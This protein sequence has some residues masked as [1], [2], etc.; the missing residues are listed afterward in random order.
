MRVTLVLSDLAPGAHTLAL[1]VWAPGAYV[2]QDFSRHVFD[3]RAVDAA[4]SALPVRKTA[5]NVWELT[6]SDVVT[7]TYQVYAFQLADSGMHADRT[8]AYWNGTNLFFIVDG[9]TDQPID[10]TIRAPEG[11]YASTGLDPVG[12]APLH[13]HAP[14]YD[15][16]V[17]CPV[18]VG[19]HRRYTFQVDGKRHELAIWGSGNERPERLVEDLAKIV[20]AAADIFGELPYPHYTF[21]LHIVDLLPGTDSMWLPGWGGLEHRNSTTCG[22]V[23][24]AFAPWSQYREVLYLFSHE[25]FHLW[26][27]KRIHPDMLGPFDYQ[28][29]VYT[30]LLWA[31]EGFTDY[32]AYLILRRAGLYTVDEY[33]AA[34]A[35]QIRQL[36]TRPGRHWT[37]LAAA[38]FDSWIA[39]TDP[40]PDYDNRSVNYYLKGGLVGLL[41]DLAIRRRTQNRKSLDDVLRR[42]MDRYGR[43]GRGFPERVYQETVEEV[44]GGSMGEFFARYIEGVD[45]LPWEE[46]LAGAGLELVRRH[47]NPDRR[48]S[49]KETAV[50]DED[51]PPDP[52]YGWLGV[53]FRHEVERPHVRVVYDP[54]PAVGQLEPGDEV[55]AVDGLRVHTPADVVTRIRADYAP[56]TPVVLQVFRR[57]RLE[58]VSVPVAA[59][60]PNVYKIRRR[61]AATAEQRAVFTSWLQAPWE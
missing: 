50:R 25:F 15:V 17:D 57:G 19:T 47:R 13:F 6:G 7:V 9:V 48:A 39:F 31:M 29:E 41:L 23:R 27:V 12:D 38:S 28:A 55:I 43:S 3:V 10:L 26:N 1:P 54:G 53:E 58:T 45:E 5:K 40:T 24:T 22:V 36:E 4:G 52:P 11:W 59:A 60:P 49:D 33:L 20:R 8:H 2:V 46:A 37:S 34:V 21:I 61:P 16:L 44:V 42:L 30:H 32:Y 51:G 14:T 18:E 35:D 56:G